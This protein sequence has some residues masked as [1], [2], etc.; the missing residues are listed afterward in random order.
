MKDQIKSRFNKLAGNNHQEVIAM[1]GQYGSP[2]ATLVNHLRTDI[3]NR[4]RFVMQMI[5]RWGMVAGMPDGED[6]A[7]RAKLRPATA[8]EIVSHACICV[9]KAYA[10]FDKRGWS[11]AIP[12]YSD[13][14]DAVKDQENGND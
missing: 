3:D 9:E 5:E 14:V 12:S 8:D 4:A 13:V 2:P 6:A 7:G 10:E 1:R 11:F